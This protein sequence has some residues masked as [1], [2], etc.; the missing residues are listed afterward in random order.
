MSNQQNVFYPSLEEFC[1]K[2]LV[3]G[4][5]PLTISDGQQFAQR[6]LNQQQSIFEQFLL[7]DTIS[8][9]VHGENVPLI[10]L[11]QFF[12]EKGLE[13]LIEQQALKFVLWTPVVVFMKSDVPGVN[14]LGSGNLNSP[15]QCDPVTSIEQGFRWM[16]NPPPRKT[17]KRLIKKIAPLYESPPSDLAGQAVET[18]NSAYNS[19]KL[20]PFNLS[21]DKAPLTNL[22]VRDRERLCKYATELLEYRFLME[23]GMTSLSTFEYFSFF[24]DSVQHIKNLRNIPVQFNELAKL[25][26]FPD[27][28]ALY[29]EIDEPL[30]KLPK[31]R[32]KRS[33][34]KFREWLASATDKDVD[35]ATEYI[36]AITDVKGP[37]NTTVGKFTK[38]IVMTA[39]GAGV[40]AALHG[41]IE[42]TA[43][44]S[45]VGGLA[46][47]A[48]GLGLDL[49]D[50]FLLEGLQKGWTPRMFFDDIKK[51]KK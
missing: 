22:P 4:Q 3:V 36:S 39:I 13:E 30:L 43:I 19:G 42:G 6:L 25:E 14:A 9:K 11:L 15:A 48:A 23:R 32:A 35:I 26:G 2:Y 31:L 28:K 10:L 27:L 17:I 49:L 47:P 21:P 37:V 18:A 5:V 46:E 41:S 50:K 51:L 38:S 45:L 33:S 29:P 40:G 1:T 12:G 16:T 44:G 24:S 20:Q 8:F 34:Q 7:F